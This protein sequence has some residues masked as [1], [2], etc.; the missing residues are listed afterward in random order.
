MHHPDIAADV[1]AT[2]SLASI[3]DLAKSN[4]NTTLCEVYNLRELHQ[5]SEFGQPR[6]RNSVV[7]LGY[8]DTVIA[9]LNP[10]AK[11]R[12]KAEQKTIIESFRKKKAKHQAHIDAVDELIKEL[13]KST[14]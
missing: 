8:F 12:V 10:V 14:S 2:D 13:E 7:M 1:Q 3:V 6:T 11:G 5:M 4:T 9:H